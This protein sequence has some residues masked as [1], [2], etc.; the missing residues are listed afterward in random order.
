MRH[1]GARAHE[2]VIKNHV[3]SYLVPRHWYNVD[4]EL[5][6]VVVSYS[7]SRAFNRNAL[8]LLKRWRL[9][10][11]RAGCFKLVEVALS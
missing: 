7:F 2:R 11:S 8:R 4:T 10:D 3:L 5:R 6:I 1:Q 9:D